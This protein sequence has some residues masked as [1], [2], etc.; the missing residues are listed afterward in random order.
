M[1]CRSYPPFACLP[2]FF[3]SAWPFEGQALF[4]TSLCTMN[5]QALEVKDL[6]AAD[7]VMGSVLKPQ[8]CAE[9]FL[10]RRAFTA[11][12]YYSNNMHRCA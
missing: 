7:L 5:F 4:C 1:F 12:P 11:P 3:L 10:L 8:G 6:H 9:G 2:N